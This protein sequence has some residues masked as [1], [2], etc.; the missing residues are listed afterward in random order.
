MISRI[1]TEFRKAYLELPGDV[2]RLAR[3]AFVSWKKDPAH[4]S[5]AFKQ[6]HASMPIYSV[7]IGLHWRA[8]AV[9]RNY[10]WLWYWIG[11]HAEYDK[12]LRNLN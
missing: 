2:R 11:S 12:I 1:T 7:R 3:R 5:L 6:I 9:Q 10:G 8:L 4:P